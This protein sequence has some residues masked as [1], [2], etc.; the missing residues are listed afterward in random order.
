[1]SLAK[2]P[3][4]CYPSLRKDREYHGI[5]GGGGVE[6]YGILPRYVGA[7]ERC[8]SKTGEELQPLIPPASTVNNL[9]SGQNSK[10][11]LSGHGV[12]NEIW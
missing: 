10:V 1:M 7:R 2:L 6:G 3:S 11:R 9:E 4:C 12:R 8:K 5:Q